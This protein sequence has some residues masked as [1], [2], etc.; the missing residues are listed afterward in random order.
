M[1]TEIAT[2]ALPDVQAG[3]ERLAFGLEKLRAKSESNIL[4]VTVS[5]AFASKWLLPRLEQFQQT[6]PEIELMLNTN[7]K[8]LDF[9]TENVDIGVRYGRGA[10]QGV[11]AEKWQ[12]ERLFPVCSPYFL[13]KHPIAQPTDLLALPLDSWYLNASR[14]RFSRR[15]DWFAEKLNTPVSVKGLRINDSAAVL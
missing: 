5:P 6:F 8:S 12:D 3:F 2:L 4:N 10:W 14:E 9:L 7:T 1:P 15:G 11:V 13:E